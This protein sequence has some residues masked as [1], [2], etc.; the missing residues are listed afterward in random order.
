MDENNELMTHLLRDINKVA[1]TVGGGHPGGCPG[2][3]CFQLDQLPE[4]VE[5]L[6]DLKGK[7]VKM[8]EEIF[9]LHDSNV[10]LIAELLSEIKQVRSLH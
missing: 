3:V 4:F 7:V 9:R 1:E 2:G 5:V 8:K 6:T 10:E